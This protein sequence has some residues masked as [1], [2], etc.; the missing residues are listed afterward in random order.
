MGFFFGLQCKCYSYPPLALRVFILVSSW[1]SP[2]ATIMNVLLLG[3]Q[4]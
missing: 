1:L 3:E 2:F 4:R